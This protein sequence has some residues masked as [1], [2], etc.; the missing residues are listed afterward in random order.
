M[1]TAL[2]IMFPGRLLMRGIAGM[3]AGGGGAG[4]GAMGATGAGAGTAS[5]QINLKVDLFGEE[6]INTL[7][8]LVEGERD[9]RIVISKASGG[10]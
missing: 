6:L 2:D 9:R 7:V 8:D 4:G 1:D 10:V 3:A 5:P